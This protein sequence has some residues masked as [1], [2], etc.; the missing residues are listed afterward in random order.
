MS[1]RKRLVDSKSAAT[2]LQALA[3]GKAA[4]NVSSKKRALAKKPKKSP[5][6]KSPPKPKPKPKPPKKKSAMKRSQPSTDRPQGSKAPRAKSPDKVTKPVAKPAEPMLVNALSRIPDPK[7]PDRGM[8]YWD[9]DLDYDSYHRLSEHIKAAFHKKHAWCDYVHIYVDGDTEVQYGSRDH[10]HAHVQSVH[11]GLRISAEEAKAMR[12]TIVS[13]IQGDILQLVKKLNGISP[14]DLRPSDPS[15]A[16]WAKEQ[17]ERKFRI[18]TTAN[19]YFKAMAKIPLT[20]LR[21]K[22]VREFLVD[23]GLGNQEKLDS[24]ETKKAGHLIIHETHETINLGGPDDERGDSGYDS[25]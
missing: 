17:Q 21:P 18:F 10:E 22:P 12:A 13:D 23:M 2:R 25:D 11:Y 7:Y 19:D 6:K 20:L 16:R 8:W 9:S 4:R 1:A 3:R 24:L 5:P 14:D 15:L